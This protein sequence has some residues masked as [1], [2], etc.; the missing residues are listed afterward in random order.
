MLVFANDPLEA[1]EAGP[2]RLSSTGRNTRP[3]YRP[4]VTTRKN[5]LKKLEN[6]WLLDP[7]SRMKARNVENPQLNTAGPMFCSVATTRSPRE[8]GSLRNLCVTWTE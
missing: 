4:N 3:W 7:A 8:P 5:I 1:R 2:S 6:T